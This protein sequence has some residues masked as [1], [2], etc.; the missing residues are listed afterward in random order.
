MLYTNNK[1][2]DHSNRSHRQI[3]LLQTPLHLISLPLAFERCHCTHHSKPKALRS[4]PELRNIKGANLPFVDCKLELCIG[5]FQFRLTGL[6]HGEVESPVDGVQLPGIES[7]ASQSLHHRPS[8]CCPSLMEQGALERRHIQY[9][10]N[11]TQ[12]L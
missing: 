5:L 10:N 12:L 2:S 6:C 9:L 11:L 1:K 8:L 4:F 7:S 3:T